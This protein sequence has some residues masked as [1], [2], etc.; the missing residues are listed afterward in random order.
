MVTKPE[1]GLKRT[2]PSCGTRYYDMRKN[3]PS[4]PNCGTV[5]DPEALMR[6]RRRAAPEEK[7]K[8]AI[9]PAAAE[10]IDDIEPIEGDGEESVIEDA[11]ELGDEESEL[12]GAVELEGDVATADEEG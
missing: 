7:Q 1:W 5:F 3:P 4:C 12:E 2:C 9:E 6:S 11:G 10:E 8:K